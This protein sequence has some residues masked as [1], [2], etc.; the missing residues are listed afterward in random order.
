[1][2]DIVCWAG[3]GF[4]ERS[5][6]W[7]S[8]QHQKV[9]LAITRCRTAAL[10]GHRDRCS[11]CGHTTA[12]SYNSCRNRHCPRC[13]V[14]ARLRWLQAREQ[15]L[16]ATRYVHLVFT[17]PR[18]LAPLALQNK[19]VV[20]TCSSRPAPPPCSRS[21]H[22]S[23]CLRHRYRQDSL[24]SNRP[25]QGRPN[26]RQEALH[27]EATHH[28]YGKHACLFD[29]HGGLSRCPLP[30]T[31]SQNTGARSKAHACRV[32]SALRQI[33]QERLVDA[34]AIAE[35]VQRPTMRFV[36]IK[37]EAQLDLQALHRVRD[38]WMGRRTAVINQIRGFLLEH[39]ITVAVGPA[40]IKRRIPSIWRTLTTCYRCA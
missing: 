35:A 2:A 15:E 16:L 40:H 20:Y 21:S 1:M 3:Q 12:I 38:R 31:R 10:G 29:W 25:E 5:R 18:E 26:R 36:P 11:A 19:R 22:D 37:S 13:Q 28:P 4:I 27:A 7:I 32:R 34:E 17:L 6:R 8:W 39:G 24:S 9:L 33:E 14:N 30:G 23:T